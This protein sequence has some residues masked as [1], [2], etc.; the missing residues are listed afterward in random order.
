M[1]FPKILFANQLCKRDCVVST[2]TGTRNMN[3]FT[4]SRSGTEFDAGLWQNSLAYSI[5]PY[6]ILGNII[7]TNLLE[8]SS[9]SSSRSL[10]RP[11]QQRH[12]ICS[13]QPLETDRHGGATRRPELTTRRR[14]R[15]P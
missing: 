1:T 8:T 14:R 10:D 13:C 11:A 15:R 4:M 5:H 12:W 2:R 6:E 9:W 3:A 7:I